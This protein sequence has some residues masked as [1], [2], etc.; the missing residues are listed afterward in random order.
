MQDERWKRFDP[1]GPWE[2]GLGADPADKDHTG[3]H[4]AIVK[5]IVLVL[6]SGVSILGRSESSGPNAKIRVR[7]SPEIR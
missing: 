1:L 5:L 7:I 2:G 6:S 4:G 3:L